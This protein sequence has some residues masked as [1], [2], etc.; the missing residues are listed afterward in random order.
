MSD[1]AGPK[2]TGY[3]VPKMAPGNL[4]FDILKEAIDTINEHGFTINSADM[5]IQASEAAQAQKEANALSARF[6]DAKAVVLRENEDFSPGLSPTT[7]TEKLR[8]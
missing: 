1:K 7:P 3:E 2:T 4:P 5:L 8:V 6:R